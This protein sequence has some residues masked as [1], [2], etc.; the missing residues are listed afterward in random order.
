MAAALTLHQ[1]SPSLNSIEEILP[2]T[3]GHGVLT[4]AVL[5]VMV[6]T[7]TITSG[8]R[9]RRVKGAY[10]VAAMSIVAATAVTLGV[11]VVVGIVPSNAR[12]CPA[13]SW[14]SMTSRWRP[15]GS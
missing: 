15:G 7:A 11:L 9:A 4:L 8:T 14:A 5:A 13:E 10:R 6:T 3:P 12:A 2:L 1:L